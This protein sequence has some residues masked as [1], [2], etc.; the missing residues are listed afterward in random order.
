VTWRVIFSS[1][2]SRDY[3]N[4]DRQMRNRID[5]KLTG[6]AEQPLSPEHS[7][8]LVGQGELRPRAS[9]IGESCFS[10]ATTY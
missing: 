8:A 6:I 1:S 10:Y 2:A 5:E 3:K 7:K 4:L 9:E